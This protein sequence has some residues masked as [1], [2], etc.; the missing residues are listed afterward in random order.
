VSLAADLFDF[1]LAPR[2]TSLFGRFGDNSRYRFAGRDWF[3]RRIAFDIGAIETLEIRLGMQRRIS[4][5]KN[6]ISPPGRSLSKPDAWRL[7]RGLLSHNRHLGA[8]SLL[9][10]LRPRFLPAFLNPHPAD[11]LDTPVRR[12]T[13]SFGKS[14]CLRECFFDPFYDLRDL[15]RFEIARRKILDKRSVSDLRKTEMSCTNIRALARCRVK[16]TCRSSRFAIASK[17]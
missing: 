9:S 13:E 15:S 12:V 17:D 3:F 16:A 2:S 6:T 10:P 7:L 4:V 11:S 5:H 14:R 1:E 8:T